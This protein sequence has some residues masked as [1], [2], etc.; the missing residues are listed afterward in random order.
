MVSTGDS[1]VD[2]HMA[3]STLGSTIGSKMDNFRQ[4]RYREYLAVCRLCK[5]KGVVLNETFLKKGIP[6]I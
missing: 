6:M 5:E 4:E 2:S 3:P 1:T